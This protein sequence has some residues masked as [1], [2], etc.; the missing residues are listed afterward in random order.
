MVIHSG[1]ADES[2][3]VWG[4][5][6]VVNHPSQVRTDAPL[7]PEPFKLA[8][9]LHQTTLPLELPNAAKPPNEVCAADVP[10]APPSDSSEAVTQTKLDPPDAASPQ[11]P[12][13]QRDGAR[14]DHSRSNGATVVAAASV[15]AAGRAPTVVGGRRR[16]LPVT[17]AVILLGLGVAVYAGRRGASVD[18]RGEP[19]SSAA[20]DTESTSTLPAAPE[21]TPT[22]GAAAPGA[23]NTAATSEPS[24]AAVPPPTGD[25]ESAAVGAP[26]ADS[27]V[28]VLVKLSPTDSKLT[29]RGVAVPGP[30]FYVEVPKG[31]K[32]YL[33]ASRK[34]Y[35]T[36]KVTVDANRPEITVGLVEP[37]KK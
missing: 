6:E 36:R 23:P 15:D 12:N 3:P 18:A 1:D 33:E 25:G 27:L 34:G 32:L 21:P 35:V 2:A 9:D 28:R 22:A 19:A 17:A 11:V 10:I 20:N 7:R 5:P 24:G 14:V 37:R 13:E 4:D 30:P 31:K 29:Y 16:W 8:E 26:S